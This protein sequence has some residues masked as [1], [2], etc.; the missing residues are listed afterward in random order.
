MSAD[1]HF[2]VNIQ[3]SLAFVLALCL[4]LAASVHAQAADAA[5]P[6][7]FAQCLKDNGAV[8]Y[9][10]WWCPYCYMQLH[11]IAPETFTIDLASELRTL[12]AKLADLAQ[13]EK[14]GENTAPEELQLMRYWEGK[15][16]EF[17]SQMRDPSRHAMVPFVVEC[18]DGKSR[19]FTNTACTTGA[20][21]ITG[22]PTWKRGDAPMGVPGFK[23]PQE[24]SG[25][26]GC[27][28]P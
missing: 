9:S 25:A 22:T 1:G 13:R 24:L 19:G 11:T 17:E 21:K 6:N 27:P 26:T 12:R 5:K 4:P 8:M 10:A 23:T 28:L 18:T 14:Q 3:R 7:A 2:S 20:Q 15:L 16:R